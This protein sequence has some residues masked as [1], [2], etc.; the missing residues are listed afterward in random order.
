MAN[1]RRMGA[2]GKLIVAGP[3][4]DDTDLR[5]MFIFKVPP[6]RKRNGWLRRIQPSKPAG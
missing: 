1:I 6:G 4:S 3:F 5:G 2:T